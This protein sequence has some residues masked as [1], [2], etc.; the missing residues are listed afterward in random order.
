MNRRR[1]AVG[2]TLIELAMVIGVLGIISTSI[3]ALS[4]NMVV[5]YKSI[6][7]ERFKTVLRTVLNEYY[8][9]NIQSMVAASTPAAAA[10]VS[11]DDFYSYKSV[12]SADIN[13]SHDGSGQNW[14]YVQCSTSG[15]ITHN[16]IANK[17]DLADSATRLHYCDL[18]AYTTSDNN[19]L[20]AGDMG[21]KTIQNWKDSAGS[22]SQVSDFVVVRG[23]PIVSQ[24]IEDSWNDIVKTRTAMEAYY[25]QQYEKNRSLG[26]NV[27]RFSNEEIAAGNS[28]L[29]DFEAIFR[30][31]EV[32]GAGDDH[33]F[34]A[35]ELYGLGL[36]DEDVSTSLGT[37]LFDNGS[38]SVRHPENSN[39]PYTVQLWY[40]LLCQLD[41][42][43]C[44]NNIAANNVIIRGI[45]T[46]ISP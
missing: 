31:T 26:I 9:D 40:P 43:Q 29:Y 16:Q 2:L 11:A 1:Q 17:V 10:Q 32:A 23:R 19:E 4:G 44:A 20:T 25:K 34:D 12:G 27:S 14:F 33:L 45:A 42:D 18:I 41:P 15:F 36:T 39:P 30:N 35:S 28:A 6:S 3:A 22:L 24:I 5:M 8:V 7:E 46:S 13:F 37:M 21:G 38:T